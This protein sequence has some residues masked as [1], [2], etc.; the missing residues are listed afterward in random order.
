MKIVRE[1]TF[2]A[3]HMLS[4][5]IGK[6][7]NLHGHTYRVQFGIESNFINDR[8]NDKGM[9]FDFNR[10]KDIISE[11]VDGNFDH[12]I[13]FSDE[14]F[15]DD[16]ENELLAWAVKN[17]K[18]YILLSGKSTAETI[19]TTLRNMF[20]RKFLESVDPNFDKDDVKIS[21]KLWETP[22]SFVEC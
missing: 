7:S 11:I 2:D 15:R 8:G 19:A 22:N 4:Y 12:A 14:S 16:A 18:R 17:K 3:A 21:V 13:I 9:L 10:V 5:Y 1:T 6:C 20:L